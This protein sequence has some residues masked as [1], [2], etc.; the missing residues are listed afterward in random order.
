MLGNKDINSSATV[1][2]CKRVLKKYFDKDINDYMSQR[3]ASTLEIEQDL[4]DNKIDKISKNNLLFEDAIFFD[5]DINRLSEIDIIGFPLNDNWY[6]M[7]R[8][9]MELQDDFYQMKKKLDKIIK[10]LTLL[11][12]TERE[13]AMLKQDL[14]SVD[15]LYRKFD[16]TVRYNIIDLPISIYSDLYYI[17]FNKAKSLFKD[18]KKEMEDIAIAYNKSCA[19]MQKYMVSA[20]AI[21]KV[22]RV[23]RLIKQEF[24]EDE[25]KEVKTRAKLTQDWFNM[26]NKVEIK[27]K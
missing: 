26:L 5:K 6:L 4:V 1:D 11:P 16:E 25:W 8:E 20:F 14:F 15:A 23:T 17:K 9:Y 3:V 27:N 21:N 12:N 22:M 7:I 24:N 18:N 10:I 2:I 13:V 19:N